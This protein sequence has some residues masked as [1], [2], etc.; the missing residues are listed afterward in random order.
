MAKNSIK[1]GPGNGSKVEQLKERGLAMESLINCGSM[2]LFTVIFSIFGIIFLMPTIPAIAK[3]LL[4]IVFTAPV[5]IVQFTKGKNAGEKE[6]KLKNRT[7][8][9]DIHTQSIANVNPF[10]SL[11]LVAPF[12]GSSILFT[13]IA[14]AAKVKWLEG[15]MLVL[16]APVTMIFQGIGLIDF[17]GENPQVTWFS[18]LAISIFAVVVSIAYVAGYFYGVYLLK[19]R[20]VEL[21]NEIRSY[22]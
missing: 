2:Y 19:K 20:S 6:Y 7:T 17:S 10:K 11:V 14:V 8:L 13:V 22:E 18:V 16:F 21:I 4:G 3:I 1:K 9:S 15:I 12:L 5:C